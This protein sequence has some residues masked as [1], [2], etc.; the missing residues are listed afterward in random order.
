MACR[1]FRRERIPVDCSCAREVE[2]LGPTE[3]CV[4]GD[5]D[6]RPLALADLGPQPGFLVVSQVADA[7]V[8][9]AEELDL[10]DEVGVRESIVDGYVEDALQ[11]GHFAVDAR[12]A[13]LGQAARDV[14][15]HVSYLPTNEHAR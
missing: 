15:L 1:S 7:S 9:F 12:R 14:S 10:A 13:N 3:P 5:C 2:L 8:V 6:H 11:E 4:Q